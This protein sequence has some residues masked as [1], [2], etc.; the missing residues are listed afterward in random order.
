MSGLYDRVLAERVKGPW[1]WVGGKRWL[2]DRVSAKLPRWVRTWHEPFLGGGSLYLG[3]APGC[4]AVLSDGNLHLVDAWRGIQR[5]PAGALRQLEGWKARHEADPVATWAEAKRIAF[6][7]RELPA[8]L[9][10]VVAAG[11]FLYGQQAVINGLYRCNAS[12]GLNAALGKT[13][14]GQPNEIKVDVGGVR[15]AS[16][17]LRAAEILHR[18]LTH[19]TIHLLPSLGEEDVLVADPPY[20]GTF[21]SY[22]K[23]RFDE[24]AH[25]ALE[26]YARRQ[27][28]RGVPVV[29]SNSAEA[30]RLYT[31]PFWAHEIV[32]RQGTMSAGEDRSAVGEALIWRAA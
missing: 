32:N 21:D 12:G 4:P 20:L 2:L 16:R 28:A 15:A 25:V 26:A 31:S 7:Y 19:H 17:A 27:A 5:D 9:G 23:Y 30:L 11:W 24:P 1:K 18:P 6:D 10:Q 3:L 8:E 29:L 22:T 14:K 13:S